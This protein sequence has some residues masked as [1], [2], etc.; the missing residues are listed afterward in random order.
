MSTPGK[1]VGKKNRSRGKRYR[2]IKDRLIAR[3]H[4]TKPQD[5]APAPPCPSCLGFGFTVQTD[6]RGNK[7]ARPCEHPGCP[8][9]SREAV[10]R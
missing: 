6:E 10:S 4:H 1:H 9:Q 2:Q 8:V 7:N 5:P 3:E